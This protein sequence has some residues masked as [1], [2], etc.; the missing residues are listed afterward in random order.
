MSVKLQPEHRLEFLS[1]T[2][3]YTGSSETTLRLI[4]MPHCWKSHV[5][6]QIVNQISFKKDVTKPRIGCLSDRLSIFTLNRVFLL[7][8]KLRESNIAY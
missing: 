6:A 2:G 1:F 7:Q 5:A 3:G 4:K 8:C